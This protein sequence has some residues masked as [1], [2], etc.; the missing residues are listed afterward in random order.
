MSKGRLEAFSDGVLAIIITIMVLELRPPEE[1]TLEALR[2]IIPAF[3]SYVLSFAIVG[4]YWNNHHHLFQAV[5]VVDGRV[6]W[7]NLLLLFALSLLPFGS[8]WMGEHEFAAVP[9]AVYG[10]I[11]LAAAMAF[12]VLVRALLRIQPDDAPL[13]TAI[14]S[15]TK[16]KL[17]PVV[18]FV[19][20]PIA[21]VAPL[22]SFALF[23]AVALVWIVPD[24]R[25]ER[26]LTH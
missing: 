13:A 15:D 12:F 8:A 1:T 4:I 22:V 23:V 25:I 6:L 20:I 11:L 14:G 21:L 2:P 18:Y 17:S 5:R 26:T 10:V 24:T 9:V 7:A 3:L 16:G 19:S